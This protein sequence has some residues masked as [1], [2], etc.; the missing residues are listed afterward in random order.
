MDPTMMAQKQMTLARTAQ[1]NPHHSFKNLYSL[2][3]WDYWIRCA[4]DTVLARPGSLT[5]AVDGTTRR[6]RRNVTRQK[7]PPSSQA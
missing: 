6:A 2:L 3:H 4:A 5:A 1:A 7:S